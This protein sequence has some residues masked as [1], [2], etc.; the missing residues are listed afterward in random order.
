MYLA[1]T[2]SAI[3]L[4]YC[5]VLNLTVVVTKTIHHLGSLIPIDIDYL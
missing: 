1:S 3:Y 2:F 4:T 5:L